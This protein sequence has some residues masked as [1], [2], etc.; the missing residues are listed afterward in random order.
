MMDYKKELETILKK[1]D[2][3]TELKFC[4]NCG[5]VDDVFSPNITENVYFCSFCKYRIQSSCRTDIKKF[6]DYD[7][8]KNRMIE[9][10]VDSNKN[11]SIL[12]E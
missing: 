5:F 6:I 11:S 3:F 4:P 12:D 7:G 9:S 2:E 8:V 10:R 1:I